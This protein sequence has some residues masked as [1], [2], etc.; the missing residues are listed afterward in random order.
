M[1][2]RATIGVSSST[3][4]SLVVV[5]VAVTLVTDWPVT[6]VHPVIK[7]TLDCLRVV[8]QLLVTHEVL[9]MAG[10]AV[11]VLPDIGMVYR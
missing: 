1:V 11:P 6:T 8:L 10:G 5:T 2:V 7:V 4:A 9:A 3:T